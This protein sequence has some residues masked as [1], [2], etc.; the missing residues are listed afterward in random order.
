MGLNPE[1]ADADESGR[2]HVQQKSAQE[3]VDR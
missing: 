1:V 3:L 2:Q